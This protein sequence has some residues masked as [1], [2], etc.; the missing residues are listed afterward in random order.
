MELLHA[1]RIS[2]IHHFSLSSY[3]IINFTPGLFPS[4]FPSERPSNL[5]RI[6]LSSTFLM[7]TFR[8]SDN[9]ILAT[10]SKKYFSWILFL[11]VNTTGVMEFVAVSWFGFRIYS[12]FCLNIMGKWQ[13]CF[14]PNLYLQW[15]CKQKH[16]EVW[17]YQITKEI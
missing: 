1:L 12:E 8:V 15:H 16:V 2:T 3:F 13:M 4:F 14:Q 11:T 9:K 5:I 7:I 10:F 6:F 17:A